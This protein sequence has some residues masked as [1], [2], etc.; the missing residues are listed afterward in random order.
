[1]HSYGNIEETME[2]IKDYKERLIPGYTGQI[3][4]IINITKK[5]T[6]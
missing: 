3:L 2:I 5:V 6:Y 4:H 1:M